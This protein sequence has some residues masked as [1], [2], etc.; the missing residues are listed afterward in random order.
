MKKPIAIL[1]ILIIGIL[2]SCNSGEHRYSFI[3]N[4]NGESIYLDNSKGKVIFINSNNRISDYVDLNIGENEIKKIKNEKDK[5][6]AAQ[7][8]KDWDKKELV[9][10][11]YNAELST[12]YYKDKL[13]YRLTIEPY[14][15]YIANRLNTITFYLVDE[16]GFILEKII[17]ENWIRNLDKKGMPETFGSNGSI[18]MTIENY[19]EIIN[20]NISW[21]F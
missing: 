3:E 11:K 1:S 14:D 7:K 9:G 21:L 8:L 20:W 15:V 12:R 17:P 6:D 13:I 18:S 2:C 19:L 4:K 5:N 10:T 16:S